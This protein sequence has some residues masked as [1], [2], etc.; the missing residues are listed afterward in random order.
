MESST[1]VDVQIRPEDASS[2]VV[3]FF[4]ASSPRFEVQNRFEDQNRAYSS[5][6][7]LG[8][9]DG[10]GLVSFVA[11]EVGIAALDPAGD[12][13]GPFYVS[14]VGTG[15]G[16]DSCNVGG[17]S[18]PF[19]SAGDGPA[20]IPALNHAGDGFGS[21]SAGYGSVS[22]AAGDRSASAGGESVISLVG[23]ASAVSMSPMY[24]PSPKSFGLAKSQIW[25]LEWIKVWLKSNEEVKDKD[26]SALLKELEEDFCWINLVARE[27][28]RLEVDE[29]DIRAISV[30]ACEGGHWEVD[31]EED[32]RKVAWLIEIEKKE[33]LRMMV[34]WP[35]SGKMISL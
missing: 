30:V 5:V 21:F 27:Q 31:E 17:G 22:T 32:D 1:V 10:E 25:L 20:S 7:S 33:E 15:S 12:R 13:S 26:H 3:G 9:S 29:K 8:E 24:P 35:G 6:T 18:G 4:D 16:F 11:G 2:T 14:D 34:K 28:G 19:S 23:F